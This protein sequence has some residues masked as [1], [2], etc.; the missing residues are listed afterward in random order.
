MA[1]LGLFTGFR[2]AV[3]GEKE[4]AGPEIIPAFAVETLSHGDVGFLKERVGD[5]VGIQKGKSRVCGAIG[6]GD[7]TRCCDL[8]TQLSG[9]RLEYSN[10]TES[11]SLPDRVS[12]VKSLEPKAGKIRHGG[13]IGRGRGVR[14]R[15]KQA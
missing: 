7:V 1:A 11:K 5:G 9:L 8:E 10:C 4:G 13:K 6:V 3:P 2:Y 15:G 14:M 12:H